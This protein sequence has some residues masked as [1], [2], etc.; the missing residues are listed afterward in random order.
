MMTAAL[1]FSPGMHP[2]GRL[3]SAPG[4]NRSRR[5]GKSGVTT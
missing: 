2:G 1:S 3:I 5:S 4:L